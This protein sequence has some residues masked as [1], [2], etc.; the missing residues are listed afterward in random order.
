[1]RSK[2]LI[3]HGLTETEAETSSGL[4]ETVQ[5]LFRSL[6]QKDIQVDLG[7]RLGIKKDNAARHV[8]VCLFSQSDRN[9]VYE[10]RM[11]TEKGIFINEDLHK[12]TRRDLALLRRKKK[13]LNDQQI[14][15]SINFNAKT[16]ETE[17]GEAFTVRNGQLCNNEKPIFPS[18]STQQNPKNGRGNKRKGLHVPDPELIGKD[19]LRGKNAKMPRT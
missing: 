18:S 12:N 13:E 6:T 10:N 15:S 14:K 11:K 7:Y 2:N 16:L 9:L 1:M 5:K 8:R 4:Q 17:S 19:S 3:I